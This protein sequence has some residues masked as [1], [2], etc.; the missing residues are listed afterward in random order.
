MKTAFKIFLLLLLTVSTSA[1]VETYSWELQKK[2]NGIAVY[3]RPMSGYDFKEVRV[4]NKVKSSLSA[5][6]ALLLDTKNYP[7]WVYGCKETST[8]KILSAQEIYNYQVTDLPWPLSDRDVVAHF[9]VTQD[10]ITKVVTFA[11][12]GMENYIPA[13]EGMVR[14]LHFQSIC[15]LTPLPNDSVQIVLEMHLD[16]GGSIPDWVVNDNM[17]A[18][19][20]N[21]TI[22]MC[23]RIPLY[24]SAT[25][26]FIKEI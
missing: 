8:L 3:T 1:F 19:P 12:T 10:P 2:E 4:V 17:V 21:S 22:S 24:Q 6:V 16:A 11:K 15:Y 23:K 20:Y 25:F 9:K 18:A 5:I 14:V 7:L 13:Q 26:P